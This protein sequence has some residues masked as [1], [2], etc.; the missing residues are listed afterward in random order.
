[1]L[2]L[3]SSSHNIQHIQAKKEGNEA[4]ERD[5]TTEAEE[6]RRTEEF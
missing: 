6:L 4:V 5:S 1:M 3:A 2:W